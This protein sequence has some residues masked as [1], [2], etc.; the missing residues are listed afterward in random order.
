MTRILANRKNGRG[1]SPSG[2]KIQARMRRLTQTKSFRQDPKPQR[3]EQRPSRIC[4][5]KG[6]HG[7]TGTRRGEHCSNGSPLPFGSR[8][9]NGTNPRESKKMVG[10]ARRADPKFRRE[11]AVSP[12]QILPPR[13]ETAKRVERPSRICKN[14]GSHGGTGTRRGKHC[15]NGSP[16][17]F[18]SRPANQQNQISVFWLL[19]VAHAHKVMTS[20]KLT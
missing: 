20:Q 1:G 19:K 15:S 9:A 10:A 17:P 18:G 6:S 7:G 13:P 5:N 16:L 4:K 14:R 12:N 3:G 8:P 11:C 2:P